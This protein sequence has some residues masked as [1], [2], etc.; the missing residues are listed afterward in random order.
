LQFAAAYYDYVHTVGM[1][2]PSNTT[3]FN[4][5]AP[6]FVQKGNTMFDIANSTNPNVNLFA[7]AADYRLVDLLLIGDWHALP[8]YTVSMTAEAVRNVGFNSSQIQARTGTY[9][10]PRTSGYEADVG[11]GSSVFGPPHSWRAWAGYR[12]LQRD[13]V[14]DA[15]ND[16]DF[17]YGGTDAKGYLVTVDYSFN[18]R[19]WTRLRYLSASAI[20]GPPL[21]VDVLMLDL[22]AQF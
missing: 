3:I 12:Y 4:Y 14:L 5:T 20:N 10:A 17:H 2:N 6:A 13:A 11:F 22:N 8:N 21:L 1:R 18:R 15:F 7:L 16:E 19:I 9:V